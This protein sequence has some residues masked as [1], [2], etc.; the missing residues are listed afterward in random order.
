MK[1]RRLMAIVAALG[2]LAWLAVPAVRIWRDPSLKNH[3]HTYRSKGSRPLSFG[4]MM[5]ANTFRVRH[6][7]SFWTTYREL[8]L[9]GRLVDPDLCPSARSAEARFPEWPADKPIP[10]APGGSGPYVAGPEIFISQ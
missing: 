9:S 5:A 8:L 7:R 2:V 3:D 10:N 6:K 4:G 1:L